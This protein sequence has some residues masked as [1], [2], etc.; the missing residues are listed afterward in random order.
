MTKKEFANVFAHGQNFRAPNGLSMWD[1]A[2]ALGLDEEE[3][4]ECRKIYLSDGVVVI[5]GDG[6]DFLAE[7][8]E[9][10]CWEGVGCSCK[11]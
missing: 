8:C 5:A 6:W 1:Y 2:R 7:G 4:G 11:K 10:S 3:C 9:E